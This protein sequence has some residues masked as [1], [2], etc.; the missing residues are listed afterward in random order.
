M[1]T[2]RFSPFGRQAVTTLAAGTCVKPQFPGSMGGA[3]KASQSDCA[4]GQS[5]LCQCNDRIVRGPNRIV[6]EHNRIAREATSAP[7]VHVKRQLKVLQKA[8]RTGTGKPEPMRLEQGLLPC[9]FIV[10]AL[11]A[12]LLSGRLGRWTEESLVRRVFFTRT[13]VHFARKRYVI[14]KADTGSDRSRNARD[15]AATCS[16]SRTPRS[17]CRRPAPRS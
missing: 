14:L 6:Q 15:G 8:K 2:S 16:A 10:R 12:G 13:G 1:P 9:Q 4:L 11:A 17:R 7:D 3:S 5:G